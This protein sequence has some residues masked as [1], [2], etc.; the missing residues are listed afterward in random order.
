VIYLD[1]LRRFWPFIAGALLLFLL[2][3]WH[4]SKVDAADRAGYARAMRV[5]EAE[6][7]AEKARTDRIREETE[8]AYQSKVSELETRV[9]Q[10]LARGEPPIRMCKSAGEVRVPEAPGGTDDRAEGRPAVQPGPDIGPS[11]LVYGRDCEAIRR[12]LTALQEWIR[13]LE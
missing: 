8:R 9:D 3:S 7:A 4:A 13:G 6:R 2:W 10:L 12:Q 1:L 5:V 11:L